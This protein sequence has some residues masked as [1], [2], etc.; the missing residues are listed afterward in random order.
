VRETSPDTSEQVGGYLKVLID[1]YR[2]LER[3]LPIFA[4]PTARSG[5]YHIRDNFLRSWLAALHHSVSALSFRPVRVLLEQADTRLVQVEGHGFE[6]LVGQ[7]YEERSRL[8]V[9]DFAMTQ[10][11]QGYWDKKD[12]EIDLVA[13]NEEAR[14]IRFG[15]CKRSAAALGVEPASL[16]GHVGRFLSAHRRYQGWRIEYAACAPRI[17]K[18]QRAALEARGVIVQDL[19]DMTSHVPVRVVAN[20]AT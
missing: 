13:V 2:L 11:I 4:K 5:R 9:G 18:A 16:E 19:R 17:D 12:T 6:R 8:G 15:T 14:I 3:R 1:R 20:P 10:R 7:L